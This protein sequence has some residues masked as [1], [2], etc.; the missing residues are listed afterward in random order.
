MIAFRMV[1]AAIVGLFLISDSAAETLVLNIASASAKRDPRTLGPILA[2]E[3]DQASRKDFA[4]FTSA[5]VG[6][7]IE[8]RFDGKVLLRQSFGS[9]SQA[10]RFISASPIGPMSWQATWQ[11]KCPS[12]APKWKSS[13]NKGRLGGKVVQPLQSRWSERRVTAHSEDFDRP[14][15]DIARPFSIPAS[16]ARMPFRNLGRI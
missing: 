11:S 3:M 2:I 1:S 7:K 4:A 5:H 13:P 9:R 16:A 10:A 14:R 12:R 6:D 8:L 15:G